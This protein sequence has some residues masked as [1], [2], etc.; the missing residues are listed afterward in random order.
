MIDFD[1]LTA[2]REAAGAVQ[3][4]VSLLVER[5]AAL[6]PPTVMQQTGSELLTLRMSSSLLDDLDAA[7]ER[8]G[9]TR[10]VIIT[11]ALAAAG[12]RVTN[13]RPRGSHATPQNPASRMTAREVMQRLRSEGWAER[14]GRGSPTTFRKD[15]R[16]VIVS[17]HPGDIPAGTLRSIARA[18]GWRRPPQP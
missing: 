12:Y 17:N 16:T 7:A 6:L 10:K 14:P 15:G 1:D 9:T 4:S 2:L 5:I 8:E 11:R 13:A 3:D 18:A